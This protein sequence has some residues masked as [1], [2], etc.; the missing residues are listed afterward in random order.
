MRIGS[1]PQKITDAE[2]HAFESF[3]ASATP[4]SEAL[5]AELPCGFVV[6]AF[7][8]ICDKCD[9][10]IPANWA[11]LQ[12]ARA[13]FAQ[14]TVETW[15]IKGLCTDCHLLTPYLIRFRDDETF[16]TLIGSRWQEGSIGGNP[17]PWIKKIRGMMRAVRQAL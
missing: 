3:I 7:E 10:S 9:Q 1:A 5:P 16:D 17:A 8:P 6:E 15:D 4:L 12:K 13:E 14:R 11:W 2:R